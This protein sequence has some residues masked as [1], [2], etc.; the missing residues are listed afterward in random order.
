MRNIYRRLL[1]II[2]TAT[3]RELARQVRYL[4]IENQILR[5]KLPARIQVTPQERNRLV[6]FAL[7]LGKALDHLVTIVHPGTMRRW[8]R[9]SRKGRKMLPAQR[10]RRR[11]A[12]AIRR[13][14]LRLGREN[15][16]GYTRILGELKKLG[17]RSI[18]R[19]TVKSI[20]K[21]YGLD[22]GPKR[23]VGTWDEFLKLHAATLWQCDFFSKRVLTPKGFR[24][25]FVLVFLHVGTRRVFV[26]P[27]SYNPNEAWGTA[28]AAAFLKHVKKSGL[29]ADI[30]MHDLDGKFTAAF[31]DLLE[32]TGLR[33]QE[34][35]PRSPNTCAFV[36]RVIQTIKQEV[37]DYFYVFGERHLTPP[38]AADE[39]HGFQ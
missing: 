5:G 21:Q 3:Q 13:L 37:L 35:P 6:R 1:Y 32:S 12:L 26:T 2:A 28:Q 8:I 27:G 31:D 29:G 33:V 15:G 18:S 14:I 34:S 4:K 7:K 16:W 22:P 23:G 36:E 38:C 24:D 30:I 25:L 17:I 9:E 10:G 19:N 20:L 11:T 39:P